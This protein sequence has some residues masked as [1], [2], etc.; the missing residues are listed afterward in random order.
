MTTSSPITNASPAMQGQAAIDAAE[1]DPSLKLNKYADPIE[2]ARENISIDDARQI[3]RED[4]SL[5]YTHGTAPEQ[6]QT[7]DTFT[8][9]YIECALWSS[10]EYAFDICPCCEQRGRLSHY[11]EPE[12]LQ[13]AVCADCGAKEIANPDPMDKNYSAADIAPET[14]ARII[15]DCAKFQA[16]NSHSIAWALDRAGHDFWLTRNGHGAGFWDGD[17]AEPFATTLTDAS[18]AFGSCDLYVGDDGQLYF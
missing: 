11:P 3:A 2:G 1:K 15:A 6:A 10:T 7:L 8:R 17:W 14:M 9:A 5:I 16:E 13:E 12:Y 18:K 4:A